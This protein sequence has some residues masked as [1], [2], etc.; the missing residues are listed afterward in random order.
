MARPLF[1]SKL[2]PESDDLIVKEVLRGIKIYLN[3]YDL[4]NV[5]PDI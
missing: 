3:N 4:F 1:Q 2:S 5:E